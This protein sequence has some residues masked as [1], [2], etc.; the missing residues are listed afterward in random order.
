MSGELCYYKQLSMPEGGLTEAVY[1]DFLVQSIEGLL[2]DS[3]ISRE[4]LRAAGLRHSRRGGPG[5]WQR[6]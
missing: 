2:A 3:G 4:K 5:R 1:Q 6:V